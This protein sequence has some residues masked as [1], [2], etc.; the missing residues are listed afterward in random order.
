MSPKR[1]QAIVAGAGVFG[2]TAALELRRRGW[3]TLLLDPGPLPHPRAASTDISKVVRMAYGADEFYTEL[4]EEAMPIWREW[5]GRWPEPLFH[6]TGV[7]MMTRTPM[8]PGEFEF[9][10]FRILEKRGRRPLRVTQAD[11][12]RRFPG[13]RAQPYADGFY[14]PE[15]GYAE[16]GRVMEK[17]LQWARLEGVAVR[18][19]IRC[20]G[21]LEAGGRVTGVVTGEGERLTADRV[22]VAAGAWTADLV[23]DLAGH[24]RPSAHPIFHFK[25][26]NT[27]LYDPRLFP[28]F[29]A[30]ISRTGW[31]GFP[32]NRDGLVKIARHD[33]GRI[34]D[35]SGSREVSAEEEAAVRRFLDE[36]FP[37]LAPLPIAEK[38]LCFY[39]DTRDEHFW[40]DGDP[41]RPGLVVAS[42]DSGH[43]FKFAPVL[44]RIIADVVEEKPSPNRRRFR[45]RPEITVERGQEESRWHG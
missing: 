39:C 27:R 37:T 30:D 6:E 22:I 5:N 21:F 2:A 12:R 31:Y 35:P 14:H 29:T 33:P 26:P 28:V 7:L 19:E 40:I 41:A 16:S 9:E 43:A 25:P 42:G 1:R 17:I 23:P 24:L 15:G 44:G 13:W 38:R 3:E 36:T 20:A 18:P 4:M 34:L 32:L 45:W 10:S 11:L 8:L